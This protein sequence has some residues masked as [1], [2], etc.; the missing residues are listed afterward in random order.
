MGVIRGP[1]YTIL[2]QSMLWTWSC[3][4]SMLLWLFIVMLKS[5]GITE[6]WK[7]RNFVFLSHEHFVYNLV[8]WCMFSGSSLWQAFPKQFHRTYLW[9]QCQIWSKSSRKTLDNA[10]FAFP[11]AGSECGAWKGPKLF[12]FFCNVALLSQLFCVPAAIAQFTI[13]SSFLSFW[14]CFSLQCRLCSGMLVES[15]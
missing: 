11:F 13:P 14:N 3:K 6:A 12:I 9:K 7:A 4:G 2:R 5:A 15:R 8:W 1:L 10:N